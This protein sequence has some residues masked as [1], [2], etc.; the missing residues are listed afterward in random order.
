MFYGFLLVLLILVS[1]VLVLAVLLQAGKGGGLAASFGGAASSADA[2]VGTRQAANL[3]T[4]A[5]WV[6]GGLF[7]LIGFALSIM[8]SRAAVGRSVLEQPFSQPAQQAPAATPG[9]S[10]APAVPLEPVQPQQQQQQQQ[11]PTGS[12]KTP[13]P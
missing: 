5:S 10:T 1:L 8:S 2:F 4:Q 3:L 13:R 7:L 6:C 9:A 11:P 12:T